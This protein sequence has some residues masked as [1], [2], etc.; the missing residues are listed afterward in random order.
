[1][2]GRKPVPTATKQLR[3][4]PGK[5]ALNDREAQPRRVLPRAPQHLDPEAKARWRSLARE[6][7]DAGLLTALD[8]DALAIY[9]QVW[10]RWVRAEQMLT[11]TSDVIKTTN[12]NLIQNPYLG[13]ANRAIEQL[14]RME[15]E[16]GMTPS[17]RARIRVDKPEKE[18]EFSQFLKGKV[19]NE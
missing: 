3:G 14:H 5:R 12:G 1:M 4:N 6:L 19:V 7:Y 18:D 10:A 2:R 16:F 8:R 9:C 15:A 13:V 17:S 11:K